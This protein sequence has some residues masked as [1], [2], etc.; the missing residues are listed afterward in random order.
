MKSSEA[1]W[2]WVRFKDIVFSSLTPNRYVSHL[3]ETKTVDV[4]DQVRDRL[5][6]NIG[7]ARQEFCQDENVAY[8]E[9]NSLDEPEAYKEDDVVE[10]FIRANS[11]GT[12]LEK[13][14]LLFSLLISTWDEADSEIEDL[15]MDLNKTGF[16]FDRD[17]VLKTCLS[18][19]G[20]GARYQVDR[21]R[22]GKTK[23]EI[24]ARWKDISDSI[25][26][27]KDFVVGKTFI[28]H[29][30]SLPSYLALIPLVYFR[31]H[32]PQ[33]WQSARQ[34]EEYLIRSLITGAFGGNPDLLI[35]QIT[36]VI[37]EEEAFST[38]EIFGVIL[39]SGR[40]MQVTADSLLGQ[41][42]WSRELH[43]FLNLWYRSFD[44]VPTYNNNRPQV[45][46]IFPQSQ[47][48]KLKVENPQSG[49]RDLLKYG[50]QDRDQIANL[51]LLTA[52]ENGSGGKTDTPPAEWFDRRVE[53][54]GDAYLDLHLIPKD[55]ELWKMDRFDDFIAARKALLVEKFGFMIQ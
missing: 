51:M 20:K 28:R 40:N 18:V 52:R 4:T 8:Q 35:D 47:L 46:H 14:D 19:L 48:K 12:K 29:D 21:F 54:E 25:R 32:F 37:A 34:V 45:D 15:L 22:D 33:K 10:I 6:E 31:F 17:F 36:K 3:I 44:Y 55:K 16:E 30:K 39:A 9:L 1:I 7:R 50:W 11:G 2:P 49:R 42:Y 5:D 26:D 43:L 24:V 23:D 38:P 53:E 27:V 41:T 13:S